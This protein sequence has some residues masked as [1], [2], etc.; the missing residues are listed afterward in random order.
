M[1]RALLL[2]A[3]LRSGFGTPLTSDA[4]R[5]CAANSKTCACKSSIA[6]IR[7]PRVYR[8][9]ER[10]FECRRD[11][12]GAPTVEGPKGI[13]SVGYFF[14]ARPTARERIVM[15]RLYRQ[16]Q[17]KAKQSRRRRM[18]TNRYQVNTT[19]LIELLTHTGAGRP[20]FVSVLF[21]ADWCSFSQQLHEL[22]VT[23]CKQR[24]RVVRRAP[25]C[26]APGRA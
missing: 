9:L 2:L 17:A 18:R 8:R 26:C 15:S 14:E 24:T 4:S 13:G 19:E 20:A 3:A 7:T 16:R 21:Y 22:C 6:R 12:S 11:L 10:L 23:A 25:Q 1:R 5:Q